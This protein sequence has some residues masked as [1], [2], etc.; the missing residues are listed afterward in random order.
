MNKLIALVLACLLTVPIVF[1][2]SFL[3][4]TGSFLKPEDIRFRAGGV[5]RLNPYAFDPRVQY[6]KIEQFV[7]LSPTRAPTFARGYPNYYPRGTARI[8]SVRSAY[9][10][11]LRV[12]VQ[13]KDVRPSYYDN[14]VYQAWLY[15]VDSG[16]SLN[17]GQFQA[18]EGN[19]AQMVYSGSHYA[20]E[21]EYVI[22]TREPKGDI[23]PR[24][25]D[26]EIMIGKIAKR[27]YY[28]PPI[29]KQRASYGYTYYY[30]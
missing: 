17:L 11:T 4:P 28:E 29:L 7:Y 15:D 21:Y 2:G 8:Q 1:S 16:Y 5:E 10:P 22:I 14:T 23:D 20:D 6:H 19:N 12:N 3:T 9:R 25:S 27:D 26:D 18:I 13:L 24:P 30:E